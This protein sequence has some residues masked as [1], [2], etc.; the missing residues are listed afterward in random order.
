MLGCYNIYINFRHL[1]TLAD[2][3]CRR[4][5]LTPINRNGINRISEISV[6]RKAS[7]EE[8]VEMLYDAAVFGEKD[9]LSGISERIILGQSC[10]VGTNIFDVVIDRSRTSEF[11]KINPKDKFEL[12]EQE[13]VINDQGEASFVS[14]PIRETPNPYINTPSHIMYSPGPSSTT[15]VFSPYHQTLAAKAFSPRNSSYNNSSSPLLHQSPVSNFRNYF[16][17]PYYSSSPDS[18]SARSNN[19][20]QWTNSPGYSSRLSGSLETP[21]HDSPSYSSRQ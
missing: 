17:S 15:A 2:W 6:L 20:S 12:C 21:Y 18:A 9:P 11:F 19:N 3:M 10:S 16:S 5:R 1:I 13:P 8:T 7:F 4:G 14:Y